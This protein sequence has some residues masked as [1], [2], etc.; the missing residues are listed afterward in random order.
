MSER[1]PA[2]GLEAQGIVT[3]ANL[4]WN[5]VTARLIQSAI[6]R[7]EGRL[8]A[9]GP[10]VVE[11][12]AHTGRSAQDKFIV[13][14]A[15]TESTVWWGKSNKAMSPEHFAVLKADFLSSLNDKEDLFVQDL[16]GGSQPE[17]RVNVRVI[18]E[19]AWHNSF[20]RTM[21]V[22]PDE[23]DLR[24]FEADYT[25]IDLPSFRASTRRV[26]VAAARR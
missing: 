1:I 18:N 17:H 7:G 19:L 25:I 14:D 21:L 23:A 5:L 16:F 11:T 2:K 24:G 3:R 4:H 8:S 6:S 26:T 20:I 12:G 22:R 15:E 13:R 10:L 9:D